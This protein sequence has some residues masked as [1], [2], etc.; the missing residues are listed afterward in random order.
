MIGTLVNVG[1]IVVGSSVGAI[2]NKGLKEK[3]KVTLTQALGL[4]AT[5]LGMTWIVS[6]MSD[7]NRPLLFIISLVV[8]GVVGEFI[9]IDSKVNNLSEKFKQK[10]GSKLIEGITTAVLLFC[11]GTMSIIGPLE[12]ALKGNHTLLFTNAMLDGVSSMILASTFGIGIIISAAILFV[13]QGSIYMLAHVIEPFITAE[14]MQQVSIIGGILILSTGINILGIA[15]I[16][17]INL[18]PALGVPAVYY[19]IF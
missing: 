15:K 10:N 5:S 1:T 17:T 18:L 6:N 11:V 14:I 2:V 19:L 4:V 3:Y 12:S 13:W 16:K 9:D 8:G 7:N